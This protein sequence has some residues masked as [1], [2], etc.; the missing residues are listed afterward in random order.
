VKKENWYSHCYNT[1]SYSCTPTFCWCFSD[2]IWSWCTCCV[3]HNHMLL[4]QSVFIR[5]SANFECFHLESVVV[6]YRAALCKRSISY[7]NSV[8]PPVCILSATAA[9]FLVQ[10][11]SAGSDGALTRWPE[12]STLIPGTLLRLNCSSDLAAPV[13]WAFTAEGSTSNNVMTSLGGLISAF[14]QYFYIDSS[15]Q[16]QYDLVA[17]TSNTNESYCGTYTC[18]DEN[19]AGDRGRA[20]VT[21]ECSVQ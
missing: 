9:W 2:V 16:G 5:F 8:S 1:L 4:L 20:T 19:G 18:M 13:L 6:I 15:S 11:F 12:S 10:C 14:R 7:E 17:R 3:P 21:S